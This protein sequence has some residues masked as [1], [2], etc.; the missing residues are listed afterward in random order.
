M[1]KI[2]ITSMSDVMGLVQ[3]FDGKYKESDQITHVVSRRLPAIILIV[4]GINILFD[5]SGISIGV[6]L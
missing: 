5:M 3:L 6:L 1:L 4:R 2:V